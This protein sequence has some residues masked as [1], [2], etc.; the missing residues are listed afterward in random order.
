MA[1]TH[2]H[3]TTV[4]PAFAGA[5]RAHLHRPEAIL[6]VKTCVLGLV[7]VVLAALKGQAVAWGA[8]SLSFLPAAGML[9][10]GLYLRGGRPQ[11]PTLASMAS[12]MAVYLGL[13]GV[14][15]IFI[16]LRF[17]ISVP[18]I[19]PALIALDSRLGYSWPDFVAGLA[20]YPVPGRVLGWVYHSSLPQLMALVAFL[21]LTGRT[22]AL[23]RALLA[24]T[25]SLVLTCLF[26]WAWPSV[27]PS[28]YLSVAPEAAG[29]I[30]LFTDGAYGARL[31]GLVQNGLAV[32]HPAQVMGT[33]AFPSYH[34]VMALL[35]VWYLRGTVLW[36][37]ALAL[38]A[39]MVPAILAHGGHH[40]ADMGGGIV[41]FAAAAAIAAKLAPA[42]R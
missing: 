12:G 3:P 31:D 41:A 20:A 21:A 10:L 34:T 17:P 13:S 7:V 33:I 32:I 42:H 30:G 5:R 25:V 4:A 36:L 26:W 14:I 29:A 15:A 37:P 28:A 24:G 11:L 38:N 40:L 18:L 9:G 1:D 22:L 2:L 35:V 6:V 8:F 19:D 16:Y 39:A 23:H 27:G